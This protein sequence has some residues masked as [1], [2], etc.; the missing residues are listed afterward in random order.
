MSVEGHKF[1]PGDEASPR[2]I[3]MLAEEYRRA[4][5]ALLPTCRRGKPLSRAPYR[6]VSLQAIELYLN[7]LML[8]R[9]YQPAKLRA[10]QHNMA[11]R[12]L[13]ARTAGLGL[14][15]ATLDH[16]FELA[17]T[18]E[19]LVSRYGP[20]FSGS[21]SQLNRLAATLNEIAEKVTANFDRSSN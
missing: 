15:K 11:S 7:A 19:Y 13:F 4:A 16:L 1:Y 21:L 8:D 17:E 20:E 18:R 6:L 2:Q 10:L 5:S 12:A 9:G 14:R 3:L